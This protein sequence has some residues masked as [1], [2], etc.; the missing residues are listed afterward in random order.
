MV[1]ICY[2]N[3]KTEI[4]FFCFDLSVFARS[5]TTDPA[6]WTEITIDIA[7]N[8]SLSLKSCLWHKIVS[9]ACE[10]NRFLAVLFESKTAAFLLSFVN[11]VRFAI[12]KNMPITRQDA[13][14]APSSSVSEV[15][16][17]WQRALHKTITKKYGTHIEAIKCHHNTLSILYFWFHVLWQ[18]RS[19]E[20]NIR[21]ASLKLI[22]LFNCKTITWPCSNK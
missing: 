22:L 6:V 8:K 5:T 12:M 15:R 21:P 20:A 1:P 10:M 13:G 17:I 3:R 18:S 9:L 4:A 2:K 14:G 19:F 11:N 16:D 7:A